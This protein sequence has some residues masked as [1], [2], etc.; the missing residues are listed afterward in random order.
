MNNALP[1][2]QSQNSR[3][4]LLQ[5]GLVGLSVLSLAGCGKNNDAAKSAQTKPAQ[6]ETKT[7]NTFENSDFKAA[8]DGISIPNLKK[9][10]QYLSSDELGGREPADES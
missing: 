2:L 7:A 4:K 9:L 8:Y 1:F 6:I 10:I 3:K 5:Y